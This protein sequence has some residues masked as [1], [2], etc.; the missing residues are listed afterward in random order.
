MCWVRLRLACS[1]FIQ[2][3]LLFQGMSGFYL[4][5]ILGGFTTFSSYAMETLNLLQDRQI[6]LAA[7][8]VLGTNILCLLACYAGFMAGGFLTNRMR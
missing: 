3:G 7:T 1:G 4:V 8:N 5:G 2:T 6:A